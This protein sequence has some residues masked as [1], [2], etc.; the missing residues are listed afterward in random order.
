MREAGA[1]G[2]LRTLGNG[3]RCSQQAPALPFYCEYRTRHMAHY[4]FGNAAQLKVGTAGAPMRGH[5]DEVY[6]WAHRR[7]RL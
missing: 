4:F 6:A 1:D 7:Y 3:I 5:S 2:V